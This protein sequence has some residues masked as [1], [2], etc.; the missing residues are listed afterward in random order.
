MDS[1]FHQIEAIP[2]NTRPSHP[3]IHAL[4][5]EGCQFQQ[6]LQSWHDQI[7]PN[8]DHLD[9]Y[10]KLALA[11]F[12]A[13]QL[14]LYWNYTFYTCWE[15]EDIPSLTSS[16]IGMHTTAMIALS[17]ETL[18]RSYI[19]G[20]LLLFTLRMAGVNTSNLLQ[21]NE[22]LRLLDRI[23]QKGFIV[24]ERIKIDLREVWEYQNA[25]CDI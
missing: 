7:T 18:E 9:P 22:I 25:G 13:L 11:N 19:P 20:V 17:D 23:S 14:F 3:T 10:S 4:A 5:Q 12:H 1:F 16:E 2:E 24:S 8:A 15:G 6:Q 21:K